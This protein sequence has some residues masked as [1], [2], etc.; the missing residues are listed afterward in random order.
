MKSAILCI[1]TEITSGL[2]KD[3]NAS[4]LSQNLTRIGLFPKYILFSP[5]HAESILKALDFYLNDEEIQ[6]ILITGGLGPTEDDLTRE[7]LSEKFRKKLVF[8]P[9]QWDKIV[10]FYHRLRN[11]APPE[12]NKKQAYIPEGSALL[13]NPIGTAPGFM[14]QFQ[15]K[16]IFAVPGVP[17][18]T[19]FF[20]P[21]IEERLPSNDSQFYRTEMVK[22]CGIGESQFGTDIQSLLNHLSQSLHPAYLPFF[23]EVWFYLYSYCKDPELINQAETIIKKIKTNWKPYLFSDWGENLEEACGNLLRKLGLT[24]A[25]AESC[26]GGFLSHRLTNIP[27][28]SHYFNRGY[29]VYSNQAKSEDLDVSS[30]LIVT[31]GAV[32]E[33]V[34]RAL[35]EGI[36]KKTG[37]DLGIG[38]T[39]IAGPD[40]SSQ[41]KPVGLVYI[42]L[43][44]QQSTVVKKQLFS[45]DRLTVK[46]LST[47]TALTMLYLHLQEKIPYGQ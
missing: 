37:A 35:A 44:N 32:S 16:K 3:A 23:G 33:E 25:T 24:I 5:D 27:G 43:A 2:V 10:Q 14:I 19:E 36:R 31:H 7:I 38:I 39:G 28:S 30:A 34:A 12:N 8:I 15:N 29:I 1:G 26:T 4:F 20:W 17:K 42:A 46:T 41:E 47:Q 18:E 13:E 45:G 22:I 21:L 40:G 6:C 9:Q 11:T